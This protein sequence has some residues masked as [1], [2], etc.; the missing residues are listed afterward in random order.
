MYGASGDQAR[1][2][3]Y[4][5]ALDSEAQTFLGSRGND[6]YVGTAFND[7]IRSN[8]GDDRVTGGG[9]DD[10]I[11]GSRGVDTAVYSGNRADYAI[12]RD[13]AGVVHVVDLRTGATSEGADQLVDVEQ[14]EFADGALDASTIAAGGMLTLDASGASTGVDMSRG[15]DAAMLWLPRHLLGV[16]APISLLDAVVNGV[17]VGGTPTPVVDLV[18][19]TTKP[20]AKGTL[21]AAE[22]HHHT[23]DGVGPELIDAAPLGAERPAPYYLIAGRRLRRDLPAGASVTLGDLEM[24][25][26]APLYVMRRRQD[27]RFFGP[28]I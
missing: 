12:T 11:Y 15:G 19:R 6:V 2:D 1:F 21:L 9:G 13:L 25:E 5:D 8:A 17:S 10:K 7:V 27:E 22:G 24:D 14:L 28:G 18:G 3:T 26:A 16:E 23:I 4:A 20:L